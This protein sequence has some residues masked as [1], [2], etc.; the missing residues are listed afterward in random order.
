MATDPKEIFSE[1]STT[2]TSS[3]AEIP[4]LK[5][6]SDE[7]R[8][9]YKAIDRESFILMFSMFFIIF[10][11]IELVLGVTVDKIIYNLG[12]TAIGIEI[13]YETALIILNI[14]LLLGTWYRER[15]GLIIWL[16]GVFPLIL[17][18]L[19]WRVY[20]LAENKRGELVEC[21]IDVFILFS[22]LFVWPK[23]HSFNRNR[24]VVVN[25]IAN[26]IKV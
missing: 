9:R 3:S 6:D 17:A 7:T 21:F 11:L 13:V 10:H 4:P 23:V 8:K 18:N 12:P 24:N 25:R 19:A 26:E 5:N 1:Y 2:S 14:A 16:G 15:P 22:Y 20:R